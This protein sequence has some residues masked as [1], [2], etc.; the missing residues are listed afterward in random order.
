MADYLTFEI[1]MMVF[2]GGLVAGIVD[3]IAGG[4]GLVALPILLGVGLPPT[5]ALATSKFQALFGSS[6]AAISYYRRGLVSFEDTGKTMLFTCV[7]AILGSLLLLNTPNDILKYVVPVLLV[8][9]FL[10]LIF[11]P[12]RLENE[13]TSKFPR[14]FFPGTFG[15]SL[16]FYDG[17]F[18]PGIGTLWSVTL[19]LF[20]GYNL[21]QSTGTAKIYNATS[22]FVGV[23]VL[24]YAGVIV[25]PIAIT[26]AIGQAIGGYLGP[27]IVPWINSR[28]LRLS[29]LA[30]IV[31]TISKSVHQL[32]II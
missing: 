10:L 8:C 26:M 29:M 18:G 5:T 13:S 6:F 23:M 4:G 22:N 7:G 16:G 9:I 14:K 31:V 24:L 20:K 15:T 28:H 25:I 32:L 2:A 30:I 11:K 12:A 1:L 3:S 21:K 27:M 17:F 19:S